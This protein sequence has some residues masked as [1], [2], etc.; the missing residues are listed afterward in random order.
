MKHEQAT[1]PAHKDA[2][3]LRQKQ[4]L[5]GG[6]RRAVM[7]RSDGLDD[8]CRFAELHRQVGADENRMG[9]LT[10]PL[11]DLSYFVQKAGPQCDVTAGADQVRHL[12]RQTT[13]RL[14]VIEEVVT[15]HHPVLELTEHAGQP[16]GETGDAEIECG[17]L[18]EGLEPLFGFLPGAR[19][20]FLDT[21]GMDPAILDQAFECGDRDGATQRIVSSTGRSPGEFRRQ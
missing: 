13:D 12:L 3:Q 19:D 1:T 7:Q 9:C 17:R 21:R 5:A 6:I 14:R 8:R 11:V 18:A 2:S 16:G 4:M 20:H 15:A 10:L